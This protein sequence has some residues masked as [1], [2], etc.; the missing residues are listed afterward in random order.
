MNGIFCNKH[1]G[2]KGLN[3]EEAVNACDRT[4]CLQVIVHIS[5]EKV[6]IYEWERGININ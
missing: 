2:K 3:V 5:A 1:G 4:E 6:I